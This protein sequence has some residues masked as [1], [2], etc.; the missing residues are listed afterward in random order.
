MTARQPMVVVDEI[1]KSIRQ[2]RKKTCADVIE[3]GR[4]LVKAKD[5]LPYGLWYGWLENEFGWSR[6]TADN[7]IRVHQKF[8]GA[9]SPII[10]D[11]DPTT[12]YVLAQRSTPPAA[13]ATVVKLVKGGEVPSTAGVK[14]I[15][16]E[17]KN[18]PSADP[19]PAPSEPT[20]SR[21]VREAALAEQFR[22]AVA[23]L[24]A[25]AVRPSKIF[26]DAMPAG[27]LG[28]VAN[29]LT[30]VAAANKGRGS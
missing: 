13:V 26:A 10:S 2:L 27:D 19:P 21:S 1:A 30:Q 15:I 22:T 14:K 25:L 17:I 23:S 11:L 29:F 5:L 20:P 18:P 28:M 8:G 12:L 16:R 3:I 6:Q 9:R 24:I 4:L 7:F